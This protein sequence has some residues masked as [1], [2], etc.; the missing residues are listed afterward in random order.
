MHIRDVGGRWIN[1]VSLMAAVQQGE[2]LLISRHLFRPVDGRNKGVASH[3]FY[4]CIIRK[5]T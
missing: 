4:M 3:T 1:A 5:I 2:G